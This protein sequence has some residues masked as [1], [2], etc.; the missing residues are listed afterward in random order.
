MIALKTELPESE[1]VWDYPRPPRIESIDWPLKVEHDGETLAHTTSGLRIL[2]T[3]HPPCF[4]F[5][6]EGVDFSRLQP[7]RTKTFCEWK[8]QARYWHLQSGE[9]LIEDA[10]WAYPDPS[11]DRIR[12][13]VSFYARKVN[14]CFVAGERVQPQQGD[15]YGG[16]I[17]SWVKGP[18]K[19]G[20][21][22]RGW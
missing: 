7:S 11:D 18:F 19:G 9:G 21:G 13:F 6:P 15:F 3:S 1:S 5:P 20:P 12:D 8:G 2:E 10:C 16:W 17:L 14:G 4:Y 22:T